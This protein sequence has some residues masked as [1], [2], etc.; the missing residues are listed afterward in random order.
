MSCGADLEANSLITS[1]T[2]GE[3]FVIPAV[4]LTGPEYQLPDGGAI[5]V[6]VTKLK[7]EDLTTKVINGDGTFDFLMSSFHAHLK[8]EFEKNR[9]TGA[10]YTKA[11]IALT[12]AAMGNATQFL[13]GR[14]QSYWAAVIAQQQALLAQISVVT[15]RVQL[16]T[17]KVQLAAI[18]LE[19]L[20]AKAT[21]A[22][23][24]MKLATESAAYCQAQYQL[25]NLLP[26]QLAMLN[27]Q[28]TGQ[29]TQNST[30]TYNLANLLPAQLA[31]TNA[32][33]L[34]QDTS[35]SS[36][37]YTLANILP[38]QATLV[39]EQIEVQ[40]AQ[41][42]DNRT[43]GGLITGS[44]GKQKDLYTQQI[45]SYK[46]DGEIKAAKLFTDAWITMKTIDEGLLPPDLFANPSLNS[47]L[48]TVKA[49]NQLA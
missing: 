2:A 29:D 8:G 34:G 32:Q 31:M 7:N 24:K 18:Q 36:A 41:T 25:D 40:R 10:E 23:T 22:L 9:I 4:D 15:A 49:N 44:V 37:A 33:K 1:L 14:D 38:K 26:A 47:V 11:Y 3:S 21:F 19:A 13:L 46:R 48:G 35:N 39:G 45:T 42:L 17:A 5:T 6:P 12:D 27:A 30:A 43:D 16:S 28:K 20:N